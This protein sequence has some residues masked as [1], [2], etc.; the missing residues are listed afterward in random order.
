MHQAMALSGYDGEIRFV[1][2]HYTEGVGLNEMSTLSE[3]R[4]AEA[5]D[6]AKRLAESHGVHASCG[7]VSAPRASSALRSEAAGHDLLVIGSH[8]GSRAGGMMLGS[9]VTQIAHRCEQPLLIARRVVDHGDFP[10]AVLFATDGSADSWAAARVVARMASLRDADVHVVHVPDG[11]GGASRQVHEQLLLITGAMGRPSGFQDKLGAV[12]ERIC[13][14]ARACQS[15][16]V[17]MGRRGVGGIKALG[18]VS[19]RVAHR[20]SCSVLLVPTEPAKQ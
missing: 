5:L 6:Q 1:A 18:S 8:G 3:H 16:L 13:Q 15:S 14:A 7:Q 20:A 19:E 12:P 9:V 11:S 10:E 2:V 4:A 17:V